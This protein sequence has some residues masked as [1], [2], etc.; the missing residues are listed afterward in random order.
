MSV[1]KPLGEIDLFSAVNREEKVNNLGILAAEKLDNLLLRHPV[2][3]Q[4]NIPKLQPII[5]PFI[6]Q[7]LSDLQS[8]SHF[9]LSAAAIEGN[10]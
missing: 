1:I 8:P 4:K 9:S 7:S 6:N 2:V 3:A 10:N 5:K